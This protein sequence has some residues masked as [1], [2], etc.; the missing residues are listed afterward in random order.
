MFYSTDLLSIQGGQF[1]RIWQLG[2]C[3]KIQNKDLK[4]KI[5]TLAEKVLEWINREDMR[6]LSLH[7]STSLAYG[8][9]VILK[10]QTKSLESD[11]D[12]VHVDLIADLKNIQALNEPV[13]DLIP[14]QVLQDL[15]Q[16]Q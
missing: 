1:A 11:I 2:C 12:R 15:T 9:V 6:R 5:S 4:I 7:L 8:V 3:K 10:A 14:Q 13:N 16:L